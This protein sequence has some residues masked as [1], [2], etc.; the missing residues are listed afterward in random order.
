VSAHLDR[1]FPAGGNL[2]MLDGHVEWR[3]F[4]DTTARTSSGSSPVFWW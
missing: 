3:K 2:A 1:R 4:E